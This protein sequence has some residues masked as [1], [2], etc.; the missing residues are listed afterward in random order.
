MAYKLFP[1]HNVNGSV[2]RNGS[3]RP[4][5]VRLVQ[6]LLDLAFGMHPLEETQLI[7]KDLG[8]PIPQCKIVVNGIYTDDLAAYIEMMQRTGKKKGKPYIIDGKANVVPHEGHYFDLKTK[9]GTGAHYILVGINEVAMIHNPKGFLELGERIG[10]R[11]K[12]TSS[13]GVI[14]V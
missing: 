7:A 5:D 14:S 9:T 6:G 4:D 10:V 11:H 2:G 12:V 1:F 8:G 3:N 13:D